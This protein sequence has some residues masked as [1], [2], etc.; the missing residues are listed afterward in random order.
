MRRIILAAA[1][2]VGSVGLAS[3]QG[4]GIDVGPG[5]GHVGPGYDYHHDGAGD[6][7]RPSGMVE[8]AA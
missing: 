1:L 2:F 8:I 7:V 6:T 3:A 5:G 4:V